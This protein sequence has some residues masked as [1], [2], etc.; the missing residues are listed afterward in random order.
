MLKIWLA[1]VMLW[2][3]VKNSILTQWKTLFLQ[4]N[5]FEARRWPN[6]KTQLHVLKVDSD[7]AFFANLA[8]AKDLLSGSKLVNSGENVFR[9]N[10]TTQNSGDTSLTA[11]Q[12]MRL[13]KSEKTTS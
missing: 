5:V 1:I 4:N 7:W 2:S 12:R 13:S 11:T 10:A 3:I 8:L 6:K 9:S